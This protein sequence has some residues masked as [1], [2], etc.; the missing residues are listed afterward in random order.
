MI[1]T[2]VQLR[3]ASCVMDTLAPQVLINNNVNSY[4]NNINN[5]K[6]KKWANC[7]TGSNFE[8]NCFLFCLHFGN[9]RARA[10]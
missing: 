9:R 5:E 6:D 1:L 10:L 8:P 4:D 3:R 7:V 2:T